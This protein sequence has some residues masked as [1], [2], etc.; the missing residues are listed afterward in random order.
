[1]FSRAHAS[2]RGSWSVATTWLMPRRAS[3]AASTPVPVPMSKATLDDD[4]E[5]GSGAVATRST[6]SRRIGANTP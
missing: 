4:H 6:Y 3:T 5:A 1:M 2:A